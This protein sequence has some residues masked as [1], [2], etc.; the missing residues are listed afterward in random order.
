MF[1]IPSFW[2]CTGKASATQLNYFFFTLASSQRIQKHI[3]HAK[4]RGSRSAAPLRFG[5]GPTINL[6]RCV[7]GWGQQ[8][9]ADLNIGCPVSS[10]TDFES[11]GETSTTRRSWRSWDKAVNLY[12]VG[13]KG[14]CPFRDRH[15]KAC[16]GNEPRSHKATKGYKKQFLEVC[17][18]GFKTSSMSLAFLQVQLRVGVCLGVQTE[19]FYDKKEDWLLLTP[20]HKSPQLVVG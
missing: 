3:W 10:T 19:K 2:L 11:L 15:E 9:S 5:T 6:F 1:S 14:K 7:G 8:A 18:G 16:F 13:V 4:H 20:L 12:S 17:L